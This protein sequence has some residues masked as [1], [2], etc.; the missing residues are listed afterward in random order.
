[1]D[2]APVQVED[3]VAALA[4]E[5]R[6]ERTITDG[7]TGSAGVASG[8][9]RF[10]PSERGLEWIESGTLHLGGHTFDAKRRMSIVFE[11]G[12]W[13]V[14]FDDERP[15]HPLDLTTGRCEVGH[16]CR[17]D[18]YAGTIEMVETGDGPELR[19]EWLVRGP[20]KD[21]RIHTRYRRRD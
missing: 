14:R 5:W 20:A 1:M 15:F 12:A 13:Q 6:F 16:P 8:D 19:T 9:A 17:D 11:G 21:Q 10:E 4:G 18:F 2:S 3:P 7:L